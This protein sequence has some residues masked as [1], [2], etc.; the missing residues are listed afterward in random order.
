MFDPFFSQTKETKLKL[1]HS[2]HVC[3]TEI[4][5]NMLALKWSRIY[6]LNLQHMHVYVWSV[7]IC[8]FID[9]NKFVMTTL[10]E[11][12][13]ETWHQNCSSYIPSHS[14][15]PSTPPP[16]PPPLVCPLPSHFSHIWA[17]HSSKLNSS[18]LHM[19]KRYYGMYGVI[20][21]THIP[22]I[23]KNANNIEFGS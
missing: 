18:T 15:Y 11:N 10:H 21:C 20:C 3:C 19:L 9:W 2:W 22:A 17:S 12:A 23:L 6:R 7:F 16:P 5:C 4:C 14:H 8:C 1:I 13:F